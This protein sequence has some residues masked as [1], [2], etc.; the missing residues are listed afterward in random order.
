MGNSKV[1]AEPVLHH[2]LRMSCF[3]SDSVWSSVARIVF[4]LYW[5]INQPISKALLGK[6]SKNISVCEF[7]VTQTPGLEELNN[8]WITVVCILSHFRAFPT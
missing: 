6:K 5:G 3:S 2:F 4:F 8:Y 7:A 1:R